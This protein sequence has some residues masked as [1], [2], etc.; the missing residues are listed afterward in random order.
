MKAFEERV[1]FLLKESSNADFSNRMFLIELINS[2]VWTRI[3]NGE[4]NRENVKT[5]TTLIEGILTKKVV[6]TRALRFENQLEFEQ[7]ISDVYYHVIGTIDKME[8]KDLFLLI[9]RLKNVDLLLSN[10]LASLD[11][12]E[13]LVRSRNWRRYHRVYPEIPRKDES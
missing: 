5:V 7:R 12:S 1:S 4:Q 11:R 3:D 13:P 10:I 9:S 8:T 2:L 6:R